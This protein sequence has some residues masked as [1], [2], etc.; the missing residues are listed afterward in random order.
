MEA[1]NGMQDK[2]M[3]LNALLEEPSRILENANRIHSYHDYLAV[4]FQI[5][6]QESLI[7][8]RPFPDDIPDGP[9]RAKAFV[10]KGVWKWLC[11]QCGSG[12]FVDKRHRYGMCLCCLWPDN[13][14]AQIVLPDDLDQIEE[15]LLQM[16]GH[17]ENNFLRDWKPTWPI[18][19]LMGRVTKVRSK[20][21]D[22]DADLRKLSIAPSRSVSIGEIVEAGYFNNNVKEPIDD[23]S[24][25]NDPIEFR[26]AIVLAGFTTAERDAL[27]TNILSDGFFFLN[28]TDGTMQYRQGATF[29]TLVRSD[30]GGI[31]SSRMEELIAAAIARHNAEATHLA[32]PGVPLN[33]SASGISTSSLRVTW[34]PPNTGGAPAGYDVQWRQG[35]SGSFTLVED[36]T[37][38][39]VLGGRPSSTNHQ[40]QV[41]AKN[42]GGTSDWSATDT[43]R[44]STPTPSFSLYVSNLRLVSVNSSGSY[45]IAW[46]LPG[47][48]FSSIYLSILANNQNVS[49]VIL[50]RTATT[51]SGTI[52]SQFHDDSIRIQVNLRSGSQFGL[53]R[54]VT[55]SIPSS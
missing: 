31:T 38:S 48:S 34:D 25:D 15:L 33:V 45:Q 29:Q 28:E 43:G 50:S 10:D 14:W 49:Q 4:N 19:V 44:T 27:N 23:L 9:Y 1:N 47:G 2:I 21:H 20:M 46:T 17:R 32:P 24:G 16:P 42:A 35:T 30:R 26:N 36:V 18:G 51:Y 41:R 55:F 13:Q 11:H 37:S 7:R 12:Y 52:S 22:P 54:S 39:W 40:F 3:D 5:Q 53:A 8:Y 6:H